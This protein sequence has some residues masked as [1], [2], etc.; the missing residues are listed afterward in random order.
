LPQDDWRGMLEQLHQRADESS[1]LITDLPRGVIEYYN[2]GYEIRPLSYI[3][4]LEEGAA[5]KNFDS[6][7]VIYWHKDSIKKELL[8]KRL[9][10]YKFKEDYFKYYQGF[11]WFKKI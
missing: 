2:K 4:V 6:I 11:L 7:F 9:K 1:L 10:G 8:E 3:E 5:G